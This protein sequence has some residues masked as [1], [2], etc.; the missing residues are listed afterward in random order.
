MKLHPLAEGSNDA[1]TADAII[2]FNKTLSHPF[3]GYMF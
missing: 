2:P 1:I 3:K